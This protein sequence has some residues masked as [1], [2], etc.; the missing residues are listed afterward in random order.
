MKSDND[1]TPR[2]MSAKEASTATTMSR[3][4]LSM[5][6]KEG[7]FPQPVQIGVKRQAYVRSEVN[8]WIDQRIASRAA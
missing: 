8:A 1:N 6:A 7:K 2:L 4:L 5:M 3:V